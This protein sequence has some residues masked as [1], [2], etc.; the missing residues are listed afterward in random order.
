LFVGAV[1]GGGRQEIEEDSRRVATRSDS[2]GV[3]VEGSVLISFTFG[4]I[5]EI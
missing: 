2:V 5:P 3:D 1:D 4:A